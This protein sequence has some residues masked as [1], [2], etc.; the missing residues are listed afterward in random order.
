MLE[1]RWGNGFSFGGVHCSAFDAAFI[2][3]QWPLLPQGVIN[4]IEI[5]ARNGTL[6]YRGRWHQERHLLG[7]LYL[8]TDTD[9][10]LED[11]ERYRRAADIASWLCPGERRHLMFDEYAGRFYVA[12]IEGELVMSTDQWPS[13]ALDINRTLQPYAYPTTVQPGTSRL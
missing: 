4:K 5:P 8:L 11:M 10:P 1:E 7:T 13:G 2:I 6:R 9:R 3:K 12:E